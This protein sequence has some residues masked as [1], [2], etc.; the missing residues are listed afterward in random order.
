ML[1]GA[2]LFFF[3]LFVAAAYVRFNSLVA[4]IPLFSLVAAVCF[5][6]IGIVFIVAV[7]LYSKKVAI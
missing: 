4:A 1:S 3:P 6:T 7:E 2:V 5:N